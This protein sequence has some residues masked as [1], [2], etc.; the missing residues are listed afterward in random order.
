MIRFSDGGAGDDVIY[1][2]SGA[3][4]IDGGEGSTTV[5]ICRAA[6]TAMKM[7]SP[8]VEL[9]ARAQI[10]W[11]YLSGGSGSYEIQSDFSASSGIEVIDGSAQS[12]EYIHFEY[13]AANADFTGVTLTNV[14]AIEGGAYNDSITGSTDGDTI[15]GNG[16]DDTLYGGDGDDFLDDGE[17]A[18]Q[19]EGQ[20]VFYGEGGN[21]QLWG[22]AD[23][24]QLFGGDGDDVIG[25]EEGDDIIDGGADADTIHIHWGDGSD[26]IDGGEGVTTGQDFDTLSAEWAATSISV[27]FNGDEAGTYTIGTDTGSF[28][29]IEAITGGSEADIIDASASGLAV[30]LTG[31]GG[32]DHLTGGDGSD[33]LI[34]GEGDDTLVGD[35]DTNYVLNGSFEDVTGATI[36]SV[37][38]LA[39]TVSG[40]SEAD[41][42]SFEMHVDGYSGVAATDGDY[43]LDMASLSSSEQ[44]DI[45]QA[46]TGLTV[47]ETY[48]L[49]FDAADTYGPTTMEVYFG[50]Q[51]IA[52]I[53]PSVT[54]VMETYTYDVTGGSGDGSDEL[55]FVSTSSGAS[56]IALDNI[57]IVKAGDDVI[58]GGAGDDIIDGGAG[59]DVAVYSGNWSD[60]TINESGGTYTIVDTRA[61]SPDGTDSVTNVETFRFADGDVAVADVLNDAPTGVDVT[62]NALLTVSSPIEGETVVTGEIV[63]SSGA[64]SVDHWSITHNGGDLVVDVLADGYNS[65][66][67]DSY[68]HVFRDN[69][70]GTYTQI[71]VNDDGE[72]GADGSSSWMDSYLS[73]SDL[74][75]G[76]YVL[77]I[78]SYPLNQSEALDTATAYANSDGG[79]GGDY[80]LTISGDASV[81]FASNPDFGGDWGNVGGG[82]A[83][84]SA[85]AAVGE[86]LSDGSVVATLTAVDP[87]AGDSHSFD[88]TD[89]AGGLFDIDGATGAISINGGG[90]A[91]ELD[92]LGSQSITAQVTDQAGEVYS[93]TIGLLFGTG[94]ADVIV[95]SASDDVIYGFSGENTAPNLIING[96]FENTSTGWT[97]ESGPGFQ[98][99]MSGSH[100]VTGNEGN[101]YLDTDEAPGNVSISQSVAGL[102]SGESYTLSFDTA[103]VESYD[104]VLEVYWNGALVDTISS[105]SNAMVTNS[106]SVVAGSGDGSDTVTF[107]EVGAEDIGGTGLDNVQLRGVA[108]GVT[109]TV[110]ASETVTGTDGSDTFE[111][112][113]ADN[114]TS[115]VELAAS[116]AQ[117]EGDGV[118]DYV[119]ID[120]VTNNSHFHIDNFDAGLDKIAISE[121]YSI[122]SS[123]GS[124]NYSAFR[125]EYGD[126]SYQDFYIDNTSTSA[127]DAADVFTMSF[128]PQVAGDTLDGGA[129]DD[130]IYGGDGADQLIGGAG[131]DVLNGEEGD[132]EFLLTLGDGNDI[133]I[134]GSGGTDSIN[135]SWADDSKIS[136]TT[137]SFEA[138]DW[139]LTLNSGTISSENASNLVFSADAGGEIAFSNGDVVDFSQLEQVSWS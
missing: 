33:T 64:T 28:T 67:L 89:D 61:G 120:S 134:G 17:G 97:L 24:D 81:A 3:D 53:D 98:F 112:Q 47:G 103:Q 58:A 104:A 21:D 79:T 57:Q 83:I 34:G 71:G 56:G 106:Y 54:D 84:V 38:A 90:S 115:T 59:T 125:V 114:A 133:I 138:T 93:E 73:L 136:S 78:S 2:G 130:V 123:S 117:Y 50:G 88:L 42:D 11:L 118:R 23:N 13:A 22:G 137:T 66:S 44:M 74:A 55:R 46:I 124:S 126:G 62:G 32:D 116:G 95:G 10:R 51:L 19:G 4:T 94:E 129:G 8:I 60:Y 119:V 9:L 49:S 82:A 102:S 131:D 69:G 111:V 85:T 122:V 65:G 87:D 105:T 109:H 52:S 37:R 18:Y 101:Y 107:T 36:D 31:N 121:E 16:G 26:T 91:V 127:L 108:T 70:D 14:D 86:A 113:A 40:W 110:G 139:T 63:A 25:G 15:F 5:F 1:S 12:G 45:S 29:N 39:P 30:T 7:S 100:S 77:A 96:G 41:G 35:S 43:W 92:T 68:I 80:Q 76:D 75:A 135:I 99:K 6:V 27:T 72:A 20:D 128:N 48:E 132:D